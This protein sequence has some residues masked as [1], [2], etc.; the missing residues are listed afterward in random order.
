MY[1]Y[2]L[3]IEG[4][5]Y[6]W[7]KT[8]NEAFEVFPFDHPKLS[9]PMSCV[10]GL[11]TTKCAFHLY[12]DH[13]GVKRRKVIIN[14]KNLDETNYLMFLFAYDAYLFDSLNNTQK[15][16]LIDNYKK[17]IPYLVIG[18]AHLFA[19]LVQHVNDEQLHSHI[20]SL[21]MHSWYRN[22]HSILLSKYWN[23]LQNSNHW[24][25]QDAWKSAN[26]TN[27][28]KA[29][30]DSKLHPIDVATPIYG[31]KAFYTSKNE[32]ISEWLSNNFSIKMLDKG[33]LRCRDYIFDVNK[34]HHIDFVYPCES[35]FHFC[36]RKCDVVNYY[37]IRNQNV[38]IYKVMA[39]GTIVDDGKK[40]VTSNLRILHKVRK[41]PVKK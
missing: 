2:S 12:S 32:S 38:V 7:F 13:S 33:L 24:I 21:T 35:G 26:I 28:L 40:T 29:I 14:A 20:W 11:V 8:I 37:N 36:K 15:Q 16:I 9:N 27:Q 23:Q 39:W 3:R 18:S 31:Y 10:T 34:D 19:F 30:L 1:Q 17:F 6:T 22:S 4:E 5:K 41:P 25:Y